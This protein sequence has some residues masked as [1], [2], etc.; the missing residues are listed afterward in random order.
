MEDKK[1]NLF[2]IYLGRNGAGPKL[3]LDFTK[4]IISS[5]EINN[6]ELLI[7]KNNTL[8]EDLLKIK[9]DLNIIEAPVSMEEIILHF[10]R[11]V[12]NF[13]KTISKTEKNK[14][15]NFFFIM[16]HPFN[17]VC[18]LLIKLFIKNS[19]IIYICHA[20]KFPTRKIRDF[21]EKI[22][23]KLEIILS[24]I[25]ITL[26]SQVNDEIKKEFKKKKISTLFHPLFNTKRVTLVREKSEITTFLLFGRILK[27]KGISLLLE[28]IKKMKNKDIKLIIAGDGQIEE[29]DKNTINEI[30]TGKEI[31]EVENYYLSEEEV[32]NIWDEVDV[33]LIPYLNSLQSGVIP[34]AINKAIPSIITPHK[35]LLE[36]CFIDTDN[37]VAL[38]SKDISS[39][40]FA[41]EMDNIIN[42]ENYK[43]ISENCIK[44]Q[45]ELSWNRFLKE[46]IKLL[47]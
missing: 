33:C 41:E 25:I 34:L 40:A 39:E 2:I 9:S 1:N 3:T 38:A 44:V 43:K 4:E 12:I 37:P 35:A 21:F 18:M 5:N 19:N 6:F 46:T 13:I 16:T 47:K 36:Q 8:R 29:E 28:S 45:D 42:E 22:I 23:V 27:Y 10:P 30:N 20:F 32:E 24:N 31:I 14:N 17:P 15:N 26:T 11:F 7:S